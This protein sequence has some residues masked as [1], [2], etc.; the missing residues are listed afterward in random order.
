MIPFEHYV[1]RQHALLAQCLPKSVCLIPAAHAVTRS[2][3]TEYTF[4]QNSDFWYFTGFNEADA[5]LLLS[6]HEQFGAPY[7]AMAVLGKDPDAEIWHGRRL[8]AEAALEAFDLDEAYDVDELLAVLCEWL[9]SHDNVYFALGDNPKA[10][11]A[12]QDT[13]KHLRSQPKKYHTPTAIHDIRPLVH[14]MRVIKSEQ[15]LAVMREAAKIS[16]DAHCRAM[17][18]AKPG[19]FEYQLEAEIHHAFAMKGARCPAYS[20]IVGAGN[21]ACILHYTENNA[22]T[23]DGDLILIDAGAEFHGYAADITRTFPVNG[24]FSPAQRDI[25]N[26]VLKAQLAVLE[27]MKPGVTLPA[28]HALSAEVI[29]QGLIE[30]GILSGQLQ[31]NLKEKRWQGFYMHGLGHYLGLDV[32]DVG[33]YQ[34][35]GKPRPFEV[36][37]VV[38][39]EPGIYIADD[40]DVP[41]PYRGIG[42]RIEDNVVVTREGIDMLTAG[43]PKQADEIEALMRK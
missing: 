17:K 11:E 38:T 26:L 42:V 35:H 5:W 7:R 2:N 20:T 37:M 21:N 12:L 43:V 40:A 1:E 23:H 3:D 39:V 33:S 16:A 9:D 10:D 32:H 4:R 8:G 18:F 36:G 29:T 22:Q 28:M 34:L 19:C 25:Y 24:Q 41:E 30:L 31:D 27:A 14:E 6:N 13:L 15:E